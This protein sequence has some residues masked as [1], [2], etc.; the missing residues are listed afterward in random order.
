MLALH[1]LYSPERAAVL[2]YVAGWLWLPL[3]TID[4]PGIPPYGKFTA[5]SIGMIP[6]IAVFGLNHIASIRPSWADI[7][8]V[9]WLLAPLPS[10][11]TNGLGL[12]DG[13]SGSAKHT[14]EYGIPYIAGRIYLRDGK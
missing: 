7:P 8:I 9:L 3:I 2:S 14:L 1:I 13:L 10:A 11:L 6:C 4:I 5:T 12:S